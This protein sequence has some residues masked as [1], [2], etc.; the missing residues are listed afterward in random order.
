MVVAL[1]QGNISQ[2]KPHPDVVHGAPGQ[3]LLGQC[4]GGFAVAP[5]HQAQQGA[6][7]Q[8]KEGAV[9]HFTPGDLA[10]VALGDVRLRP[11]KGP[12]IQL[13]GFVL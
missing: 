13:S 5:V 8:A 12:F 6:M 9:V 4:H 3:H 2:Q 11:A 7:R 1:E 10:A